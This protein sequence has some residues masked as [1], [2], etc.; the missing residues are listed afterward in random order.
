MPD[1][2]S[3]VMP[4]Y[5]RADVLEA[6]AQ[7]VLGQ[8]HRSLTL[9]LVD[10]GSTDN[11]RS[12]ARSLGDDRVAYV[13]LDRNSGA[14]AARNAGL[15]VAH[16][17]LVAFMDSDDEWVSEKLA[18]QIQELRAWQQAEPRVAVIGCGWSYVGQSQHRVFPR[19]PF[20]GRQVLDNQA[21]GIGTPMLLVD[22]SVAAP[23]RFDASFPALEDREFVISCLGNG[24]LVAVV[25]KVLAFVSRGRGDH[26]ANPH[27][28]SLA[29]ERFLEKYAPQL[30][31]D[32]KLRSWY[33]FRACREFIIAGQ[34]R[35]ALRHL[36]G[37]LMDQRVRRGAHIALG[38]WGSRRGLAAAQ[39]LAPL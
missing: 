5:N 10:D 13:E 14:C 27:N 20:T 18:V 35:R 23:A 7:S 37:A 17:K 9:F 15:K 2:V 32:E 34:R 36:P 31:A 38:L 8:T 19:G 16:T 25:P 33:H 28:A 22:R 6:A 30:K 1:H 3:V 11:S 12:I 29:Y 24:S 4:Y 39:K 21:A 26:V